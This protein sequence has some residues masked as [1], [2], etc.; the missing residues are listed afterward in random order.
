MGDGSLMP[1]R[2]NED[3]LVGW[4]QKWGNT[5][6]VLDFKEIRWISKKTIEAIVKNCP[7]LQGFN[8]E[9]CFQISDPALVQI[10]FHCRRLESVNLFLTGVT[11]VGF[12]YLV[13]NCPELKRIK[14]GSRGKHLTVLMRCKP[15]V[16]MK[17]LYYVC[18]FLVWLFFFFCVCDH[19]FFALWF[20]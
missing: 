14:L 1:S 20:S 3:I 19:N 12:E 2:I 9:G 10:A 18:S 15:S 5:I 8:I 4:L 11:D 16:N 7:D 13:M 6:K 17:L